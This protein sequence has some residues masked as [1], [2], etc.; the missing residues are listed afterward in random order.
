MSVLC[1][2]HYEK[3]G[4]ESGGE[5]GSEPSSESGSDHHETVELAQEAGD[6]AEDEVCDI[7][8]HGLNC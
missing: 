7:F 4:S 6:I 3:H 1:E 8:I 2:A 5:S